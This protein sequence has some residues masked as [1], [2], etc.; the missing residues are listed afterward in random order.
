[1]PNVYPVSAEH[2]RNAIGTSL[3]LLNEFTNKILAFQFWRDVQD[4]IIF[5]VMNQDPIL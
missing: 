3:S 2:N 5:L 1:M 4:R